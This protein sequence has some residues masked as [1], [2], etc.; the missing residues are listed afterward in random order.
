MPSIHEY[1]MWT[2]RTSDSDEQIEP[3]RK[4]VFI[5]EGES[6]EEW[7]FKKLI[8]RID[9]LDL[10]PLVDIRLW[11]KTDKDKGISDPRALV[12]FAHRK[13]RDGELG[14]VRGH[15]RMVIVFDADIY[16]R[17]GEGR[18]GGDKGAREYQ[19]L[20]GEIEDDDI[21]AVTNPSFELYLLLHKENAYQ[22]IV[23]PH[24]NK[25]LENRKHGRRRY[26]QVLFTEK[27][28]MNP[29]SNKNIGSLAN[30]VDIAIVEERA[31]NHDVERC[32]ECL[33]SNVGSTIDQIRH[34]RLAL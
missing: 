34:D 31:L 28:H 9:E 1:G 22:S 13:K 8:E 6:T 17:I 7:Y 32:L 26:A 16:C 15:D 14:Y 11:E 12:R 21:P 2:T 25:L 27:Y 18:T 33:T 19:E 29:K 3:L 24:A 23:L 5:C 10:H 30:D 4:Y 20:L